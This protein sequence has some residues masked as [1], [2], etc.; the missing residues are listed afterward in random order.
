M[1]KVL[2]LSEISGIEDFATNFS[3]MEGKYMYSRL[4]GLP[5]P[6]GPLE[7][8]LRMSCM[9]IMLCRH[10]SMDIELN[11]QPYHVKAGTLLV[12][13][14]E[15]LIHTPSSD[16]SRLD[17][18]VLFISTDFLVDINIDINAINIRSLIEKR[19]PVVTISEEETG[20]LVRLMELLDLNARD[21]GQTV[22]TVNIARSLAGA[23]FY[24]LLQI[25]FMRIN[26]Q[27]EDITAPRRSNYVHDF[28]RLVHL[29]YM[30]HR[31]LAFYAEQLYITPKF[32][33]L[34]VKEST[35]R[36]ASQWINEFVI[37]EAKNLLRFSG[38]NV[39]QVAYALNFSNQSAFGKY[40]K[41]LTGISPTAYQKM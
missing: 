26:R 36:S 13:P 3:H 40:F 38:K 16:L 7:S 21:K 27:P 14:P 24:Q 33:T 4:K 8:P 2:T 34:L 22:F 9:T 18:Y 6:L 12:I 1:E 28:M 41:H 25:N 37:I 29:N 17:L 10:G 23:V 19:S 32:L 39:Q 5:R 15:M 30:K 31:A 11:M 35:G 20:K